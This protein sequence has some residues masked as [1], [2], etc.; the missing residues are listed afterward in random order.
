MS[1]QAV[2]MRIDELTSSLSALA[3][4]PPPTPVAPSQTKPFSEALNSA[5]QSPTSAQSPMAGQ[6]LPAVTQAV[7]NLNS[8]TNNLLDVSNEIKDNPSVLI[9]GKTPQRLGPGEK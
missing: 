7:N 3:T 8:V 2:A 9:R 5:F 4:P 1:L 6:T